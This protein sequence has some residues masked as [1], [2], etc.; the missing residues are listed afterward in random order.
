VQRKSGAKENTTMRAKACHPYNILHSRSKSSPEVF[1]LISTTNRTSAS[2]TT[3]DL[4]LSPLKRTAPEALLSWRAS[5]SVPLCKATD[6]F[7]AM[8]FSSHLETGTAITHTIAEENNN[9]EPV[10]ERVMNEGSETGRNNATP[11]YQ[12]RGRFLIWPVGLGDTLG[13]FPFAKTGTTT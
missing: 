11:S 6:F 5:V 10:V 12:K 1:A 8:S 4:D 9:T 13:M 3:D 2:F 7:E